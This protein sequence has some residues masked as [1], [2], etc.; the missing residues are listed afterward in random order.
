MQLELKQANM[1]RMGLATLARQPEPFKGVAM[2]SKK[3]VMTCAN[4]FS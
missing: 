1:P 2:Y 4:I 3:I